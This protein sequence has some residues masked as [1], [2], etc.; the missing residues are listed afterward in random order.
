VAET[1][2]TDP[3]LVAPF[4]LGLDGRAL[5]WTDGHHGDLWWM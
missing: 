1:A 3:P 5:A 2:T 4:L